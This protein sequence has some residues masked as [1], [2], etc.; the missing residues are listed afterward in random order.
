MWKNI[1]KAFCS[2]LV[3]ASV[4]ST[5]AGCSFF[6]LLKPESYTVTLVRGGDVADESVTVSGGKKLSRPEDPVR[7]GYAFLGWYVG[8]VPYDF[9]KL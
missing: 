1:L 2:L 6:D 3:L 5:M 4:I 9:E 8:E 7:E